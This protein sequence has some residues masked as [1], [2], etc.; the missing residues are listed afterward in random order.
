MAKITICDICRRQ[1]TEL[2]MVM[3][4]R[5]EARE[6]W[7]GRP[8]QVMEICK[9]C[10]DKIFN[11]INKLSYWELRKYEKRTENKIR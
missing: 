8:K 3:M 6:D 1:T 4:Y 9:D 10:F 2:E 11:P 5:F 7:L